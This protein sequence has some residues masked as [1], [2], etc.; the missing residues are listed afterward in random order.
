MEQ[1]KTLKNAKIVRVS[2]IL[3]FFFSRI[4]SHG[5]LVFEMWEKFFIE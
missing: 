5:I 1:N 4:I 2:L 3:I